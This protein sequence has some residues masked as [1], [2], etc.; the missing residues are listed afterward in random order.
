MR[1]RAAGPA[2]QGRWS[3][4]RVPLASAV[5]HSMEAVT[6][7]SGSPRSLEQPQRRGSP[8]PPV[9]LPCFIRD[10]QHF[11]C[12]AYTKTWRQVILGA[13]PPTPLPT[14]RAKSQSV[15]PCRYF[16]DPP[17]H[18]HPHYFPGPGAILTLP[19]TAITPDLLCSVPLLPETIPTA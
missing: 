17:P 5:L 11:T 16:S 8:C 1:L 15:Q 14:V 2:F 7:L 19:M 9:L 4:E 13:P 10:S 12:L 3:G 18:L 6:G